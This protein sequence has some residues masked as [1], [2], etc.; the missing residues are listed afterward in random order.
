ME[1]HTHA[2]LQAFAFGLVGEICACEAWEA[3]GRAAS[4]AFTMRGGPRH[5]LT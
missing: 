1:I 5:H 2:T 3:S 4:L